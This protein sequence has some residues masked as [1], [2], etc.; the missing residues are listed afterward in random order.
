MEV[1]QKTLREALEHKRHLC[2]LLNG[3]PTLKG[4]AG[5]TEKGE[6]LCLSFPEKSLV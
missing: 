6:E 3:M 2:S 4:E 5:G 1:H